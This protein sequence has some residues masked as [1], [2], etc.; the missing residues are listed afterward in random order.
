[1]GHLSS[2]DFSS[3]L[4][5]TKVHYHAHKSLPLA[6]MGPIHFVK[7]RTF[8]VHFNIMLSSMPRYSEW[9]LTFRFSD[10]NFCTFLTCPKYNTW[11]AH[12]NPLAL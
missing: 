10:Q 7:I 11:P 8:N 6:Q 1:M 5:K 4:W 12:L 3:L 9:S 2:Q